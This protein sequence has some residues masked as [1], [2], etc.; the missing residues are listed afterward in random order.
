MIELC[1]HRG[2]LLYSILHLRSE[3]IHTIIM[4]MGNFV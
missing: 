4:Y 2:I 1:Y 3:V